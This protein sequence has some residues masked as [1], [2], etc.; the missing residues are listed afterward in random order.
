MIVTKQGS[1]VCVGATIRGQVFAVSF[2]A[3]DQGRYRACRSVID[4][5][6]SPDIDF[7]LSEA[8]RFCNA[9]RAAKA[10]HEICEQNLSNLI[11]KGK[12]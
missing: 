9:I 7:E 5:A 1:T 8:A 12:P 10:I 4:W 2:S 3:N 6:Q 11:P